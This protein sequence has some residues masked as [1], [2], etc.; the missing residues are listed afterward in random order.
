MIRIR[1]TFIAALAATAV[2]ASMGVAVPQAQEAQ[3]SACTYSIWKITKRQNVSCRKA[4]WVL[5]NDPRISGSDAEGHP[6]WKCSYGTT[7]I[8]KG[9]CHKGT[10]RSFKYT[11]K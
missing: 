7:I 8:P 1:R 10:T 3:T 9:R 11:Q 2:T 6:G 4:K 5:K